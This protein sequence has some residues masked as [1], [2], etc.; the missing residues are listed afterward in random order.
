M[1]YVVPVKGRQ[2]SA[3]IAEVEKECIE[4]MKESPSRDPFV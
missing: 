3:I 4:F 1:Y 2:G